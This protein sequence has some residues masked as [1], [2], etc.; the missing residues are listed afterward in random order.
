MSRIKV[1]NI[2]IKDNR[3]EICYDVSKELEH[4]FNIHQHVFWLEYSEDV[5]NVPAAIA[6]IPFVC[7]VLPAIWLTDS[8]L[9]LAEI[10]KFFFES[11]EEFKQGY[12]RMYPML[13]FKG[14]V[15]VGRVVSCDHSTNGGNAAF[16]S[17]GVDAFT[18]LICHKEEYPTLI[19][20]RGADVKLDDED[21]WGSVFQHLQATVKQFEL[22]KPITV[23]SNFRSFIC[24]G[25]LSELVAASGDGWWHGFQ[26]GI[27]IISHAA[28]V[29]WL[30]HLSK[31]Y[32]ASSI[33]YGVNVSCASHYTIDNFLRFGSCSVVH[34]QAQHN[35]QEKIQ[36]ITKYCRENSQSIDTRVCWIS[37]GG[38]NCCKCEKCLRT[39]LAFMAEGESPEQYGFHYTDE[40]LKD[41]EAIVKGSLFY[42]SD[43]V[44]SDWTYVI[45][46]FHE[47]GAYKYDKRI[48]WVYQLDPY[49]K[50]AKPSICRRVLGKAKRVIRVICKQL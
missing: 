7:N 35:R 15:Q 5:S 50:P 31:V 28:P 6:V 42:A 38:Q 10:D 18:T 25:T 11:V 20:L 16:F 12:K 26:H 1:S 36:I 3:I 44:R 17:G 19:T 24:E 49:A 33:A 34:D 8:T 21:G 2:L 43:G 32:I 14:N 9:E 46:R 30:R 37:R 39:M 41:S 45:N 29:A 27:G 47:T 40:N 22:P 23:A 48:N 13:E 4:F